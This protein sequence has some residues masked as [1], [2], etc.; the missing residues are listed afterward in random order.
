MLYLIL[1]LEIA[2]AVFLLGVLGIA[3]AVTLRH[4]DPSATYA[5]YTARDKKAK[6][7]LQMMQADDR[8]R[9]PA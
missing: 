7:L 4:G 2:L 8:S 3:F 5:L 9:C 6:Q 1:V